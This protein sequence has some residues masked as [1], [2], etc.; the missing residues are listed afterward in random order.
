MASCTN[1]APSTD[2]QLSGVGVGTTVNVPMVP[3]SRLLKL[4]KA[5]LPIL[6][7]RQI[8]VGLDLLQP[9]ADLNL[10]RAMSEDHMV[11][12]GEQIPHG[13]QVAAGVGARRSNL[14]GCV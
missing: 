8:I 5:G 9:S 14:R 2:R 6:I 1:P 4:R 7:L 13:A 10:M 3:F 11:V 12:I